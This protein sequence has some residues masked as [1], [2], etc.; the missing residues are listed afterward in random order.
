MR[1]ELPWVQVALTFYA[2]S[3]VADAF[4]VG[5]N[6]YGVR[7]FLD[8]IPRVAR[9]AL[10]PWATR[11]NAFGVGRGLKHAQSITVSVVG[12]ARFNELLHDLLAD[13]VS[14]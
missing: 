9:F 6:P 7:H 14:A 11:N 12:R 1:S 5:N 2:E 8:T 10:Q 13:E 4:P 3:V